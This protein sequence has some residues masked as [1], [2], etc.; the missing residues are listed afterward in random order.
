M[1]ADRRIT[2]RRSSRSAALTLDFGFV[3]FTR[4]D[5]L[6]AGRHSGAMQEGESR[7]SQVWLLAVFETGLGSFGSKELE[8][9]HRVTD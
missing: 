8:E 3:F 6:S 1:V 5:I 7:H 2:E 9:G 4:P